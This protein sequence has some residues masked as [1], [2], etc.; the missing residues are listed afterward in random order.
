M[1]AELSPPHGEKQRHCKSLDKGPSQ[2]MTPVVK[3]HTKPHNSLFLFHRK[4]LLMAVCI[5]AG[6]GTL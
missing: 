4:D 5:I 1:V 2:W 3:D 6:F